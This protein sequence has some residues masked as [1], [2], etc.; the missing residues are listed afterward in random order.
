MSD[1]CFL[2]N[3]IAKETLRIATQ[4]MIFVGMS[5]L[6][7]GSSQILNYLT[8]QNTN[9]YEQETIQI[10]DAQS[11]LSDMIGDYQQGIANLIQSVQGDV[12]KFVLLCGKGAFNQVII[13]LSHCW[14]R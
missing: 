2:R 9:N 13:H 7:G 3:Q 11:K 12:D 1:R 5:A 8:I 4:K 6:A 14:A 10:A